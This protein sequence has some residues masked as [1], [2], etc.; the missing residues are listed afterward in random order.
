MRNDFWIVDRTA[1]PRASADA[2][3]RR[4]TRGGPRRNRISIM[5]QIVGGRCYQARGQ[6]EQK[7]RISLSL[8][9]SGERLFPIP[10]D[11]LRAAAI[12]RPTTRVLACAGVGITGR[13]LDAPAC[14]VDTRVPPRARG[15]CARCVVHMPCVSGYARVRMYCVC[16]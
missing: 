6:R 16:V 11:V 7:G 13:S 2:K 8:Y 3:L 4:E 14:T 1:P 5:R 15:T 9:P 12:S 10:A